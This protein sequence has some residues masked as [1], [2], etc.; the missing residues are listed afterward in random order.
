MQRTYPSVT[1]NS[2]QLHIDRAFPRQTLI[3]AIANGIHCI[4]RGQLRHPNAQRIRI[5]SSRAS[6]LVRARARAPS[7]I[8]GLIRNSTGV[9]STYQTHIPRTATT[10]HPTHTRNR[11]QI[12][13]ASCQLRVTYCMRELASCPAY[14]ATRDAHVV[15]RRIL[16]STNT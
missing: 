1:N 7:R 13:C 2:I 4:P 8:S 10:C 5:S 12:A 16:T 6:V 9:Q 14:P 3:H 15:I 11:R